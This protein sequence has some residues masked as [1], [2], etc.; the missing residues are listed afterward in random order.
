L[1]LVTKLALSSILS[2]AFAVVLSS[3]F[4][5]LRMQAVVRQDVE[6]K[7]LVLVHIFEAEAADGYDKEGTDGVNHAYNHTL[8]GF[9]ASFK[10]LL[11]MNV[12][13]LSTGKVVASNIASNIGEKLDPEDIESGKSGKT[14]VLFAR[15]AGRDILDLTV[16]LH[17]L[18]GAAYVMGV[19][20]D[21]GPDMRRLGAIV[22]QNVGIGLA[23]II[24]TG[25][26][27]TLF[28]R[29]VVSPINLAGKTFR[30]I[31][32]GHGDLTKE[33]DASR[34]DELGLMAGDFN[35]FVRKLRGIVGGIK[36]AQA[37]LAA[38]SEE[39]I[40]GSGASLASVG[41]IAASVAGA[42]QKAAG[43]SGAVLESASAIEEIA[44]NIEAMDGMVTEQADSVSQASAAIEEMVAS[45][46]SVFQNM[47]AMAER[48]SAVTGSVEEG[49]AARDEAAG[50]VAG[51]EA[52]SSSLQDANAVIASIASRTNLLAMNAAIEAAHAGE[53]G[54]GFSVVADEIRKLAENA[55]S[56][57]KAIKADI[58]AVSRGIAG[59]VESTERLGKAFAKVE[60]GMVETGRLVAEVKSA[61]SEQ[62]EGSNQL[63]DVIQSLNA[64]TTQVRGGSAEMA[65]GNETLLSGTTRL[66]ESAEG[67]KGDIEAITLALAEL[68]EGT[69]GNSRAAAEAGQAIQAMEEAVGS[70]KA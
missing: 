21:V 11:E 33:L 57:S 49:K 50:L 13:K 48:Y 31:A 8:A 22:A 66:R 64:I 27:M 60:T 15:D 47:E 20:S 12:Y 51:I 3:A 39:L 43:Q 2:L 68:E 9:S 46:A 45:I 67:M 29:S 34:R 37:Q 41:Q 53:S 18:G 7:A 14:V 4:M 42:K 65:K 44:K 55:A 38:M 10:D 40:R 25:F 24:L 35:T 26:F 30:E 36:G 58:N 32:E 61:M 5:T 52:R 63:L 1:K 59:V 19:Q 16:P 23:L 56:Q 70:F 28:S 17:I 54:K 69:G 62:R 6:S